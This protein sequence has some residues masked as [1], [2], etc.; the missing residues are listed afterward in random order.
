M[1][2]EAPSPAMD[3]TITSKVSTSKRP[4]KLLPQLDD[5]S[6]LHQSTPSPD[7]SVENTHASTFIQ[8]NPLSHTGEESSL[9]EYL[10]EHLPNNATKRLDLGFYEYMVEKG[11]DTSILSWTLKHTASGW[12]ECYK[13]KREWFDKTIANLVMFRQEAQSWPQ[14]EV[15]MHFNKPEQSAG[16]KRGR[17]VSAS[18]KTCTPRKN[19]LIRNDKV[20]SATKQRNSVKNANFGSL[21]SQEDDERLARYIAECV[22]DKD[23]GGRSSLILYTDL[24]ERAK[25]DSN[26]SWAA[27]RT[28]W[29]WFGRYRKVRDWFDAM[30]EKIVAEKHG[31]EVDEETR[32]ILGMDESAFESHH[33]EAIEDHEEVINNDDDDDT[34]AV[35]SAQDSDVGSEVPLQRLANQST[36]GGGR[37][38]KRRILSDSEENEAMSDRLAFV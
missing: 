13:S 9:A 6:Q 21:H 4:S 34:M 30:I 11:Y 36:L 2:Q 14:D 28:P 29:G 12:L 17:K 10:A 15:P 18:S 24:V 31:R 32:R 25:T 33:E 23:A 26:Y 8:S 38:T 27:T 16:G 7:V 5:T 22:P 3:K 35:D 37:S 20:D 1:K 19:N